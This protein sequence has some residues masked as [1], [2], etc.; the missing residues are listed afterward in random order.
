MILGPGSRRPAGGGGGGGGGPAHPPPPSPSNTLRKYP[1][2]LGLGLAS[3]EVGD[4]EHAF[5][6]GFRELTLNLNLGFTN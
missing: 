6:L 4:N 1:P 3:R 2:S 5:F